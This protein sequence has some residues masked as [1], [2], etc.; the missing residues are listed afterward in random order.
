MHSL[1]GRI[2][3]VVQACK[4]YSVMSDVRLKERQRKMALSDLKE[5]AY[6]LSRYYCSIKAIE[7]RYVCHSASDVNKGPRS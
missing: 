2:S 7:Y 4:Q 6:C 3:V 1:A 5:D